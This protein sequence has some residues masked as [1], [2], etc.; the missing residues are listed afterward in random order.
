MREVGADLWRGLA[1]GAHSDV[2][3]D[4]K[5]VAKDVEAALVDIVAQHGA[6]NVDDAVNFL[7]ALNKAGRRQADVR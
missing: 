6:R 4:A 2:C 7:A 5:R 1:Q 3:G